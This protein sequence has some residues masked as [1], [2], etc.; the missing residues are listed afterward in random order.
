MLL[1]VQGVPD[2]P[3]QN[4]SIYFMGKIQEKNVM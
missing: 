3:H 2:F 4:L 1:L